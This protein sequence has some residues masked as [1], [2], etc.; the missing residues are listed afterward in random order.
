MDAELVEAVDTV[1]DPEALGDLLARPV[2]AT[3]L[4]IKPQVSVSAALADACT[5]EPWGWV[6]VLWPRAWSKGR[7]R[8]AE[9]AALGLRRR[10]VNLGGLHL[11]AGGV[12][13]DPAL[14][15][16]VAARGL[17]AAVG[18][19]DHMRILRHNPLRRLVLAD[20][21]R[22]IRLTSLSQY[23]PAALETLVAQ[24]CPVPPRLDRG[25]DPHMSVRARV[26]HTDLAGSRDFEA[27]RRAGT[28]LAR[29]HRTP[30]CEVGA[31]QVR[32]L[33]G[34]APDVVARA[35]VHANLLDHLAPDLAARVRALAPC[36]RPCQG[37]AVLSHGD[38]SPDQVLVER[39][40]Q[41]TWLTDFDR[42][43]VAPPAVDL[44]SWVADAGPWSLTPLLEGYAAGGV[45]VPEQEEMRRGVRSSFVMRLMEPLRSARPDWRPALEQRIAHLEEVS[46]CD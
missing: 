17:T 41:A 15:G 24:H 8:G 16:V 28:L 11:H 19:T 22:V 40:S 29:L 32:E 23:P 30:L 3:R 4:R 38:A 20:S 46:A 10:T 21:E 12:A 43:C 13:S 37:Q 18:A 42:I 44:G 7:R 35:H 2:V 14:Q 6:Q 26:G 9:A 31:A 5:L 33:R 27:V 45:V 36:L 39:G 1:C 25:D 34:R